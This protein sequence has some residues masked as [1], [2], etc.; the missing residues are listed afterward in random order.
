MPQCQTRAATW[1]A[2]IMAGIFCAVILLGDRPQPIGA[3]LR[4]TMTPA[5]TREPV[6]PGIPL[7]SVITFPFWTP[8]PYP[9]PGPGSSSAPSDTAAPSATIRAER[10]PAGVIV[11][12][13]R[14]VEVYACVVI[15][16]LNPPAWLH[17][18]QKG[19]DASGA[20][21]LDSGQAQYA[22]NP[23]R[24]IG[25]WDGGRWIAGP[26]ELPGIDQRLPIVVK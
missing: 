11:V 24:G 9:A 19:C 23:Q 17:F 22:G 6:D 13:A 4:P 12:W 3:Q 5:P 14:P 26:V 1:I 8:A 18:D 10:T 15:V 7:P 2:I 16:G 25:L 21:L 20:T